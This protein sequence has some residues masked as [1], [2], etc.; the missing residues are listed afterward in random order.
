MPNDRQED[1][2]NEAH[3]EEQKKKREMEHDKQLEMKWRT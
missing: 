1:K 3:T 2:Q